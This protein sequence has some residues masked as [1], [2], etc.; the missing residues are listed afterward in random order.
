MLNY[1]EYYWIDGYIVIVD[2]L[3]FTNLSCTGVKRLE[4][5]QGCYNLKDG[6]LQKL[7]DYVSY[8]NILTWIYYDPFENPWF[9]R[10]CNCG[11]CLISMWLR[12]IMMA[13]LVWVENDVQWIKRYVRMWLHWHVTMIIINPNFPYANYP[14]A[15]QLCEFKSMLYKR[16]ALTTETISSWDDS[17]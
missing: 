3:H 1:W 17:T 10:L 4:R 2:R 14:G 5:F 11:F 15:K 13:H 6:I 7:Y 9:C 8:Q 12:N 16:Q